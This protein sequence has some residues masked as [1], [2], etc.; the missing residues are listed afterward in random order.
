MANFHAV[1]LCAVGTESQMQS[2]LANMLINVGYKD[3]EIPAS[4]EKKLLKIKKHVKSD[5]YD[6]SLNMINPETDT[7]LMSAYTFLEIVK[8]KNGLYSALFRHEEAWN[9][10]YDNFKYLHNQ[11]QR[12][13]MYAIHADESYDRGCGSIDIENG[14]INEDYDD[15]Y[16]A[17]F[18]LQ[19]GFDYFYEDDYFDEDEESAQEEISDFKEYVVENIGEDGW[20]E[21][22]ED[23]RFNLENAIKNKLHTQSETEKMTAR[24][25]EQ[26]MFDTAQII[27]WGDKRAKDYLKQLNRILKYLEM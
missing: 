1:R 20:E 3:N 19:I 26:E 18:F 27:L 7:Q 21:V 11:S 16:T 6:Y 12:I 25:L 5:K 17:F 14:E 15:M 13:P 4:I 22:I 8:N 23:L 2:M 24:E 9:F 10:N